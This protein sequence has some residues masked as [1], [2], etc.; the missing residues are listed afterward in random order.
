VWGEG[1]RGGVGL[2]GGRV[3]E[4]KA[5]KNLSGEPENASWHDENRM[6]RTEHT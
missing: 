3:I 1:G 2:G 4:E 5:R 6:Y